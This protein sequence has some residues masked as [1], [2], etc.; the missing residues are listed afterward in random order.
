MLGFPF[1]FAGISASAGRG[2]FAPLP[3]PGGGRFIVGCRKELRLLRGLPGPLGAPMRRVW[4]SV[5]LM[6]LPPLGPCG[7]TG[8][9]LLL[10]DVWV[11]LPLGGTC[12]PFLAKG[13]EDVWSIPGVLRMEGLSS[14]GL[15]MYWAW[16]AA[17]WVLPWLCKLASG[18]WFTALAEKNP[19]VS[20]PA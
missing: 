11:W 6:T 18:S 16:G 9:K 10:L 17:S 2:A 19:T 5:G 15:N 13:F 7:R 20:P 4:S 12:W 14:L 8:V 1:V 3:S